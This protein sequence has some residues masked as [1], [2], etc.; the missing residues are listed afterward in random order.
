MAFHY[1]LTDEDYPCS[2]THA[3]IVAIVKLTPSD[4]RD[5]HKLTQLLD[6]LVIDSIPWLCS[7]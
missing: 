2:V 1:T 4:L 3:Y 6:C 5:D 7:S